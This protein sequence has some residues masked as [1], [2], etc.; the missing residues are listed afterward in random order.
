MD[1]QTEIEGGAPAPKKHKKLIVTVAVIL[2]VIFTLGVFLMVWYWGDE[3]PDFENFDEEFAIP[4][5][6]EGFIPQGLGSYEDDS[7][8]YFFV[9]GYMNDGSASRIYVVKK[10]A[11]SKSY[12]TVGY[13]TV[14]T[15]E[16]EE[17][18]EEGDGETD[19]T[20]SDD[21]TT[22]ES[23]V[24][25]T[26][27]EGHACGV[28]T[29]GTRVWLVGESKVYVLSYSAVIEAAAEEGGSVELAHSY[30]AYCN[31]DFC[32]YDDDDNYLYVGEFYREGNYETDESHHLTT[33]AGDE[34]KALILRYS[35][36]SSSLT[37]TPTPRRGYSITGL[38]QGMAFFEDNDETRLALST[39]Y[40]LSNSHIL[41]YDFESA[42]TSSNRTSVTLDGMDS[43]IYVYYIDS[44][45]L[46]EDYE[47][48][49][50][51]EGMCTV[52]NRVYV[53]FESASVKYRL[54]VRKRLT[55]VYSFRYRSKE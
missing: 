16:E 36:S 37:Y 15:G 17:T 38:V 22:E 31:A 24:K 30:D 8:T 33:S 44:D 13:V 43:S 32:Y 4:A 3:Y 34:N 2:C 23:A 46:L 28:A 26:Y 42:E 39:S 47:I 6:D 21:E 10:D 40:G 49:S 12:E 27:Y 9:S 14:I 18:E 11:A 51:S 25:Y 35:D 54:F 19:E 50:M 5:L 53:L 20:D 41:I 1:E 52:G 55:S 29:N 7:E 45:Y 48:P